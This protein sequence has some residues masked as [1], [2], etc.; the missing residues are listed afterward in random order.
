MTLDDVAGPV[1]IL[2]IGLAMLLY[3]ALRI[4]TG[5]SWI[6]DPPLAVYRKEDP[7]SFW[8]S[9]VFPALV[10]A[11]LTILSLAYVVHLLSPH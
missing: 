11:A 8:L 7:F 10:G 4:R 3:V 2:L 5:K 1:V 9:L 6:T